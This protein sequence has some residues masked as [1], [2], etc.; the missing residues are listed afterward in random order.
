M[1][2]R[3]HSR[4]FDSRRNK[5][6]IVTVRNANGYTWLDLTDERP[7]FSLVVDHS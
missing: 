6:N 3:F 2:Q 1:S 4:Q 5:A 7:L